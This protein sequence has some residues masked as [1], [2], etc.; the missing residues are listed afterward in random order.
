AQ[1]PAGGSPAP[2]TA[3]SAGAVP[4]ADALQGAAR[5]AYESA[6]LLAQNKDFNGALAEFKHAY[7]LSKD[8]RLLF[9]MA[10]CQ[11]ELHHYA[12]MRSLLEQ[13]LRDGAQ[14]TTAESQSAAQ[15]ALAAIKPLV[16]SIH[17]TVNEDGADVSVD[18]ESSGTSPLKGNVAVDLGKHTITVKKSGFDPFEQSLDM[19]GGTEA[20]VAVTLKAQ[21]H[22]G[23]LVVSSDPAATV[24]VDGRDAGKGRFEGAVAAGPHDVTVSETGKKTYTAHVEL[25][26][27]ETRTMD[28]TLE[29]ES[30]GMSPWPWIVGGAVV[31]AG[32]AVGGYFLFKPSDTTTTTPAPA[33]MF[34][35]V[36]FMTWRP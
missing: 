21:Q 16:A 27:G 35:K 15:D 36:M 26:D 24:V 11:K 22:V 1:A 29:D 32:A 34:G 14:I 12:R 10:I 9:N 6:K 7:E 3:G 2:A 25:H 33:G 8:P 18:G 5:T 28:V 17:V 23:Q 13:Y 31:A 30:H 19:P 4:L 20:T